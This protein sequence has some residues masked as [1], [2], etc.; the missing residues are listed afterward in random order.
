MSGTAACGDTRYIHLYHKA[1]EIQDTLQ[2][3]GIK[4]INNDKT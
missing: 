3:R 1:I 4:N 2:M